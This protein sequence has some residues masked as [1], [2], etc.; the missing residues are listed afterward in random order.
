VIA[1]NEAK[2]Y[3][4]AE[5]AKLMLSSALSLCSHDYEE[6]GRPETLSKTLSLHGGTV[7]YGIK[8]I[9]KKSVYILVTAEFGSASFSRE[10]LADANLKG[11]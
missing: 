5:Q 7:K 6:A 8:R 4:E 9:D 3:H 11:I 2:K 1:S 10:M